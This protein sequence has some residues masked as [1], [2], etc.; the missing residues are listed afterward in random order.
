MTESEFKK[1]VLTTLSR[2]GETKICTAWSENHVASLSNISSKNWNKIRYV[3]QLFAEKNFFVVWDFKTRLNSKLAGRSS[4][5]WPIEYKVSQFDE[6]SFKAIYHPIGHG[7]SSEYEKVY[8]VGINNRTDFFENIE[9]YMR[10]NEYDYDADSSC[11]EEIKEAATWLSPEER[12]KYACYQKARDAQFRKDVLDAFNHRCVVCGCNIEE[13]LQAAHEHGYEVANTATD[14]PNHGFCLCANH[15]LMYDNY[16]ID[17]K[18]IH[19]RIE[20]SNV[21][22]KLQKCKNQ[23]C[24]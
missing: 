5:S 20:V 8:I 12:K 14:D 2:Y 15:H 1:Y 16:L 23:G 19:N 24:F 13:I 17:I 11:P 18:R 10:F 6:N 7:N 3:V 21:V 22:E 4:V 9:L